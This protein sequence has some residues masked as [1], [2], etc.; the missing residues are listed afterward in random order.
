MMESL[1]LSTPLYNITVNGLLWLYKYTMITHIWTMVA[2]LM[3]MGSMMRCRKEEE[4]NS[5]GREGGDE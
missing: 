2:I 1:R 4:K 3:L 5:I